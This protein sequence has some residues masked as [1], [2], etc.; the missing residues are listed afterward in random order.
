MTTQRGADMLR[1]IGR[2]KPGV[3]V[4]QARAELSTI[5]RQIARQYPDTNK[6][7]T[8]AIVSSATGTVDWKLPPRAATAFRGCR[9]GVADRLR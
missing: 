1:L 9:V 3:T 2:L 8:A 5:A 6:P 7:Y 4:A